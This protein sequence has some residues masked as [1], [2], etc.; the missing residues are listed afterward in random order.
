V[1]AVGHALL[2]ALGAAEADLLLAVAGPD[3]ITSPA[4]HAVRAT[5][6]RRPEVRPARA[7]AFCWIVDFPLFELDPETGQHV[8]A[9]H[10]FT[11]PHP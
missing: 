11:A 1:K 6:T 10:P 5:L 3:A 7:H 8:P 2:D 4:L 9:H